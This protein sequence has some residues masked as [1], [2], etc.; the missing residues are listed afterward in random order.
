MGN[1]IKINY[2]NMRFYIAVLTCAIIIILF[3]AIHTILGWRPGGIVMG[4]L[5]FTLIVVWKAITKT[6]KGEEFF[7]LDNPIYCKSCRKLIEDSKNENCPVCDKKLSNK[8]GDYILDKTFKFEYKCNTCDELNKF[9]S[10]LKI[11]N[12]SYFMCK[13]CKTVHEI[14]KK[15]FN[16]NV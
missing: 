6:E 15:C 8:I 14:K 13:G 16:T 3:I 4:L 9:K 10:P 1:Y 11:D 7:I 5:V 12:I 2:F